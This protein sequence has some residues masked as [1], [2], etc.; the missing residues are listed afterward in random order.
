MRSRRLLASLI[1]M[2]L[3]A[4][5]QVRGIPP[6]VTSLGGSHSPGIPA[7]VTSINNHPICCQTTAFPNTVFRLGTNFGHHTRFRINANFGGGFVQP[8]IG[9][10]FVQPLYVEVPVPVQVPVVVVADPNADAVDDAPRRVVHRR[11]IEEDAPADPAP[12]VAA[13]PQPPLPPP[14]PLPATVLI[15]KDGHRVEVHDYAISGDTFYDLG[16]GLTKK[17]KLSDLDLDATAKVN[18]D[19][20]VPFTVP[21]I[22]PSL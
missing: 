19:R 22:K 9:G 11:V 3:P 8:F 5:A 6:S 10:G 7:S 17:I 12:R 16:N 13:Q 14:K 21:L 15:F 18:E 4:A 20:G 2:A 1:L